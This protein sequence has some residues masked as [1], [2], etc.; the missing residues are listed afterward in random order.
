MKNVLRLAAVLIFIVALP[1][2][3]APDPADPK[4][5]TKKAAAAKI[6]KEKPPAA[7]PASTAGD[8]IYA[9]S[10]A[11][12]QRL[13]NT[14]RAEHYLFTSFGFRAGPVDVAM[15]AILRQ[16]EFQVLYLNH[17]PVTELEALPNLSRAA[18]ETFWEAVFPTPEELGGRILLLVSVVDDESVIVKALPS[19]WSYQNKYRPWLN[20]RWHVI[21]NQTSESSVLKAAAESLPLNLSAPQSIFRRDREEHNWERRAGESAEGTPPRLTFQIDFLPQYIEA[22]K[23][24]GDLNPFSSLLPLSAD[25][26]GHRIEFGFNDGYLPAGVSTEFAKLAVQFSTDR[27]QQEVGYDGKYHPGETD[28]FKYIYDSLVVKLW[29]SREGRRLLKDRANFVNDKVAFAALEH[30]ATLL[31]TYPPDEYFVINFGIP[32]TMTSAGF[33]ALIPLEQNR[34]KYY[35]ELTVEGVKYLDDYKIEKRDQFWR[36]ILPTPQE[37]DGRSMVLHRT[38]WLGRSSS[39]II[40]DLARYMRTHRSDEVVYYYYVY[41]DKEAKRRVRALF[42]EQPDVFVDG[43]VVADHSYASAINLGDKLSDVAENFPQPVSIVLSDGFRFERNPVSALMN[44]RLA[45]LLAS[46]AEGMAEMRAFA[47]D[48]NEF[49]AE[50]A[51]RPPRQD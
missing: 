16:P 51:D 23:A 41:F 15:R 34:R 6:A 39:V 47:K 20:I 31:E 36:T 38:S 24:F 33:R 35:D 46:G 50:M 43:T 42:K 32:A 29:D 14:Y 10:L 22:L 17:F 49:L 8:S 48:C 25:D 1:A 5:K 18:Q 4:P 7:T 28:P 40:P 9:Q 45:P 27:V 11:I 37:L 2:A 13:F 26:V 44:E 19:F 30:A 3:A 12:A 21:G